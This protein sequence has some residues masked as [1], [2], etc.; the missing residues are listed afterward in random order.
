MERYE[1]NKLCL[2]SECGGVSEPEEELTDGGIMRYW[3]CTACSMEFGY[4]VIK[5]EN[6]VEGTCSLGIPAAVRER[7]SLPVPGKPAGVFLGSIGRR[8][9]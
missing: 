2:D 4:E 3:T 7:A 6:A 8:P 9:E 1:L 5:D